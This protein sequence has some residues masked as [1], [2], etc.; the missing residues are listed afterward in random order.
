MSGKEKERFS[1]SILKLYSRKELLVY[2]L[3]ILFIG[4]DF[5]LS[6]ADTVDR[7]ASLGYIFEPACLFFAFFAFIHLVQK[8]IQMKRLLSELSIAV[9]SLCKVIPL[10]A[11]ENAER[12]Q[13]MSTLPDQIYASLLLD[14]RA[15]EKSCKALLDYKEQILQERDF[16]THILNE[17]PS[18][19]VWLNPNGT[20]KYCNPA[21]SRSTGYSMQELLGKKWW[22]T[23]YRDGK[24]D[25]E[26][27][28]LNRMSA[29]GRRCIRDHVMAMP[30]KD[31]ALRYISWTTANIFD[32]EGNPV[33]L[34][35]LGNDIT[36]ERERA[37]RQAEEQKMKALAAMSGGLA[38]EISN[39]LQPILGLSEI[40]AMQAAG[41]DKKL[42]E[43]MNI[44]QRNA[45]H[46]RNIVNG[47]LSF[48]RRD[49]KKKETYNLRAILGETLEFTDEFLPPDVQVKCSG[50]N[51]TEKESEGYPMYAAINRTEM[52]QI[53]ANLF[54][55]ASHAMQRCGIIEIDLSMVAFDETTARPDNLPAGPYAVISVRDTGYGMT[56]EVQ[57]SLFQ[58]FFTTKTVGEGTGLGLAAV[59][60]ILKDWGGAIKVQSKP[61]EGS[62]FFLYIPLAQA[63]DRET[64]KVVGQQQLQRGEVDENGQY[65]R[66]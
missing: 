25:P 28:R 56:E 22:D 38:H 31:G 16:Y 37:T 3:I 58:P 46:C 13:Q 55:N 51:G 19:V 15:S 50:F 10:S 36:E 48:A 42:E 35:A 9:Q 47:V 24:G 57:K 34:I 54:T 20:I 45:L 27:G 11:S 61:G 21:L 63:P 23:L 52:I 33:E 66:H 59:Y 53:M 2:A 32:E 4:V 17:T 18:L 29:S 39:A 44:I 30:S 14:I 49:V 12:Q 5:L 6:M 26:I 64:I 1:Q 43:C 60:G 41:K 40:C 62:T 8:N 7:E 65:T